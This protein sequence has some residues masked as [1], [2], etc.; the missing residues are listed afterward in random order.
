MRHFSI[1]DCKWLSFLFIFLSFSCTTKIKEGYYTCDPN[2]PGACPEGWVC[3]M[4]GTDGIYRCYAR[5]EAWCGDGVRDP[6]EECD[7][8]DMG[9]FTCESGYPLCLGNCKA[10]CTQCGNGRIELDASGVGEECDDGNAESGDGCS[11]DCH[12]ERSYCQEPGENCLQWCGDGIINGPE[13]C[14]PGNLAG[15]SCTDFDYMGGE[16]H[17]SADCRQLDFSGC[18]GYCGNGVI[19]GSEVCDGMSMPAATC[20]DYLYTGGTLGCSMG[21]QLSREACFSSWERQ[22]INTTGNI[23]AVH[24]APDGSVFAVSFSGWVGLY[25]GA[26]WQQWQLTKDPMLRTV[27]PFSSADAWVGGNFGALYHFDGAAWTK[28]AVSENIHITGIWGSAPDDVYFC[29]F[30]S[31]APSHA[32]VMH[33]DGVSWTDSL[34][35]IDMANGF[36]FMSIHGRAPDDVR[37][38]GY[39]FQVWHYDGA[40]WIQET[41]PAN[42]A[43][44]RFVSAIG[45]TW[46]FAG[47]T[48]SGEGFIMQEEN[49][50]FSS[51]P[52]AAA[53]SSTSA[54][55]F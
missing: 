39:P 21:C 33:Y 8:L 31:D 44:F 17:C 43:D 54:M 37:V 18:T 9:D 5:A 50:I 46:V 25:D 20:R 11:A 29:G 3:Q 48:D 2:E 32:V 30:T 22:N 4:R 40:Q 38:V 52:I 45:Q 16:L 23:M 47:Y 28:L 12:I 19:E 49:G 14:E 34:W 6:Q 26:S 7:G 55:A 53:I 51:I 35:V 1:L 24:E 36:T 42:T 27:F 15:Y 41:P 10:I 13:L